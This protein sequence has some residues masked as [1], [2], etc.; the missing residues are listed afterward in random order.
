MII[1][2]IISKIGQNYI[3]KKEIGYAMFKVYFLGVDKK[4]CV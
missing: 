2:L 3:N 1:Y 4:Y